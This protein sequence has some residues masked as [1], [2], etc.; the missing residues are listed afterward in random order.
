MTGRSRPIA[1]GSPPVVTL[2]QSIADDHARYA[3]ARTC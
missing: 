3:I 1:S 2:M